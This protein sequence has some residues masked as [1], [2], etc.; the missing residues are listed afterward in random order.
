MDLNKLPDADVWLTVVNSEEGPGVVSLFLGIARYI[1]AQEVQR[2]VSAMARHFLTTNHLH[3]REE[4]GFQVLRCVC[5]WTDNIMN[6]SQPVV[7]TAA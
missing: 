1:L 2:L 5:R 6:V 3:Q 4:N 7:L